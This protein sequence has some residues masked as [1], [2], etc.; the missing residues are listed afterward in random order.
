MPKQLPASSAKREFTYYKIAQLQRMGR[1]AKAA[2][3]RWAVRPMAVRRP[4]LRNPDT[5]AMTRAARKLPAHVC[6][7]VDD[8]AC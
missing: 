1:N 4:L 3:R 5:S 2:L 7:R 6:D 8:G